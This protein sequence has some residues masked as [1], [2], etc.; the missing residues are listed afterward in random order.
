MIVSVK[1]VSFIMQK[2][3]LMKIVTIK[4]DLVMDDD[5]IELDSITTYLNNKLYEDPEFF[6]NFGS[7]NID[8][9]CDE[10]GVLLY[11]HNYGYTK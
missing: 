9:I 8:K 6:G 3:T 4:M 10:N 7:E 1:S 2:E 5:T 11:E